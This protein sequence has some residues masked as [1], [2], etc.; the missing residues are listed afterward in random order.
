MDE[1]D[2]IRQQGQARRL[3]QALLAQFDDAACA[4]CLDGLEE[5]IADQAAGEDYLTRWPAV[6]RHLDSCV[7]CAEAYALLYELRVDIRAAPL[8][9]GI[10]EADLSFL[11][12]GASGPL[13]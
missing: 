5:Y 12:E 9:A 6:A 13:T 10:P 8:P 1:L 11:Q 4:A 7:A 3:A 2:L